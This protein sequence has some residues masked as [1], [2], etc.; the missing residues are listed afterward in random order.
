MHPTLNLIDHLLARGRHHQEGG[1]THEAL[2]VL[3]RLA[4]FRE[5][6]GAVAEETQVRLAELALRRRK[7]AKA[8]R[9][10]T[11]ALAHQPENA[12]YHHLMATALLAEERGDRQRAADHFR[13][14]LEL[15]PDQVKCLVDAGLLAVRLGHT[16][17]GLA[18]LRRAVELAPN[19]ADVLAKL[20]KGLR[21]AG[22]PDEV[23]SALRAALFRNPR[24]P[25]FRRL[26]NEY[27][28][29]QLRR[30]QEA[31]RPDRVAL[32][33][34]DDGPVILPFVRLFAGTPA[35][36]GM[37][38][39]GPATVAPPHLPWAARRADQ[40]HIQGQ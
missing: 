17:E 26:W 4:D 15:D 10:L 29:R 6:P 24:E 33:A 27:R 31:D 7:Y 35:A 38:H 30:R 23:R 25:R 12:R 5:L 9:H 22:R 14:S 39:D 32:P 11:A 34:A 37:R 36:A 1:R 20:V 18:R 2:Q 3:T 21:L 19:D 28:F 40:R 13:R 8:R 16:E